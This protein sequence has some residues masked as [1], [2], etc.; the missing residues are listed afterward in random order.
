MLFPLKN[1]PMSVLPLKR[2]G[3]S[4]FN[5]AFEMLLLVWFRKT[6]QEQA[7]K[8]PLMLGY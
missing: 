2:L 1:C 8:S 3:G 7:K 6:S 5:D 4:P